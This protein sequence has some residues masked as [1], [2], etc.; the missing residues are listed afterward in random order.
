VM[1]E[2]DTLTGSLGDLLYIGETTD[3]W[4]RHLNHH[5][6]FQAACRTG[7]YPCVA[8]PPINLAREYVESAL[9]HYYQPKLNAQIRRQFPDCL[10]IVSHGKRGHLERDLLIERRRNICKPLPQHFSRIRPRPEVMAAFNCRFEARRA[11][12]GDSFAGSESG[13]LTGTDSE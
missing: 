11:T 12:D 2:R 8:F 10:R 9:I 1:H 6:D 13:K 5:V 4:K 7:F 3:Y